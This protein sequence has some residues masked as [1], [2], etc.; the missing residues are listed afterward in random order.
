[1]VTAPMD[2]V[3]TTR[4]TVPA[5]AAAFITYSVPRTAG[6]TICSCITMHRSVRSSVTGEAVWN[7]PW[8][9]STAARMESKSRRSALQRTSLSSA[10]SSAFR[11][12]FLG[13]SA[14]K[15]IT[16]TVDA[17]SITQPLSSSSLTSHDAMYPAAPVTH[18]VWPCPG[19]SSSC[20]CAAA[21]AAAAAAS[22]SAT[23]TTVIV[24][25]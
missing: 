12:A 13:S 24:A 1:M 14:Q 8:Q 15:R 6:S 16:S 9:P 3:N 7:T 4:R 17:K 10:P 18:T 11:W 21:A 2:D 19:G 25:C 20:C 5:S 22:S 23:T